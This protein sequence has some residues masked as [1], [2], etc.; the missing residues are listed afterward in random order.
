MNDRTIYNGKLCHRESYFSFLLLGAN[1]NTQ[2]SNS[3]EAKESFIKHKKK[4]SGKRART[5]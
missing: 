3:V 5:K 4:V 2:Q 1:T